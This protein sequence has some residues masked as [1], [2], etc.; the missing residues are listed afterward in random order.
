MNRFKFHILLTTCM[1]ISV[2]QVSFAAENEHERFVPKQLL[3]KRDVVGEIELKIE[4]AHGEIAEKATVHKMRNVGPIFDF[5]KAAGITR[6]TST[7]DHGDEHKAVMDVVDDEH[8]DGHSNDHSDS[9]SAGHG[10]EP[11][12]DKNHDENEQDELNHSNNDGVVSHDE[13]LDETATPKVHDEAHSENKE[14][15]HVGS[16]T[17]H[18]KSMAPEEKHEPEMFR[19]VFDEHANK[20]EHGSD[21]DHKEE[22]HG[23]TEH[24]ASDN[25]E[26]SNDHEETSGHEEDS[27]H[28]ESEKHVVKF[29]IVEVPNEF[30]EPTRTIRALQLLQDRIITGDLKAFKAYRILLSQAGK[31]LAALDSKHWQYKKNLDAVALY[32]LVGGNPIVGKTAR[33][34]TELSDDHTLYLDAAL[35]Y[36]QG[37]LGKAYR[38]FEKIDFLHV[39]VSTAAQFAIVKSMLFGRTNT[40]L[41]KEYLNVA[42]QLAPGTLAEEAA[43]R[44]LVRMSSDDKDVKLFKRASRVYISRFKNSYY[45]TDFLK[46]YAYS[47]VRMPKSMEAEVL[48][49]LEYMYEFLEDNQKLA[50]SSYVANIA[51]DIGMFKLAAWSS[52]SALSISR[53]NG[54]LHTRMSLYYLAST[55]TS[56]NNSDIMVSMIENINDEILNAKDKRLY[57]SVIALSERL[58]KDPMTQDEIKS[59]IHNKAEEQI[60][61][62]DDPTEKLFDE[63]LMLAKKN[64][65]VMKSLDFLAKSDEVLKGSNL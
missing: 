17:S 15:A 64:T 8:I 3:D 26:A 1:V 44:R 39:P 14:P 37:R 21:S 33:S 36:S 7:T 48:K 4:D 63:S 62:G 40:V 30:N 50:V 61:P 9:Q 12:A 32:T 6:D 22:G 34:K 49:S 10:S 25:H 65:T 41:A 54:K 23:D 52:K 46:N 31:K 51:T 55:V 56:I 28:G 58:Y 13:H 16:D 43:L 18:V 5:E 45:F 29:D 59:G 11:H 38:L 47:L 53:E 57:D 42:R 27:E 2:V 35:A 60:F 20:D 24:D 19:S